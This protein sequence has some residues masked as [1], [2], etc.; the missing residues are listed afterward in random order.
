M[1]TKKEGGPV[2]IKVPGLEFKEPAVEKG[3]SVRVLLDDGSHLTMAITDSEGDTLYFDALNAK[4]GSHLLDDLVGPVNERRGTRRCFREMEFVLNR[5]PLQC[6][7][8]ALG[9]LTA[10]SLKERLFPTEAREERSVPR[11]DNELQLFNETIGQNK[12]QLQ[13]VRYILGLRMFIL[14]SHSGNCYSNYN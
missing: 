1:W 14:L 10:T 3:D 2:M 12:E 4:K 9:M 8:R 6:A 13:A 7:H 5:F 11:P